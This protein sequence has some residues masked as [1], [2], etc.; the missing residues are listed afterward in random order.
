FSASILWQPSGSTTQST[1]YIPTAVGNDTVTVSVM[2]ACDTLT[3]TIY[4][5]VNN[6]PP[7]APLICGV[8]ADLLTNDYVVSWDNFVSP[9]TDYY[10]IYKETP[11]GSG[12]FS[13]LTTQSAS[14]TSFYIDNASDAS[15][16]PESYRIVRTDHCGGVSA[17]SAPHTGVSLS[18]APASPQGSLLT[19]TPYQ[20]AQLWNQNVFRGTTLSNMTLIA[21]LTPAATSYLDTTAGNWLY[22]I[23]IITNYT[24]CLVMRLA[25]AQQTAS[26]EPIRSNVIASI[27]TGIT[28]ASESAIGIS[29]NPAAGQFTVNF[30]ASGVSQLRVFDVIGQEVY[31]EQLNTAAG[32][33]NTQL[34]LGNLTPGIYMLQISSGSTV[35]TAKLVISR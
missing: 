2:N 13:L 17:P 8:T 14:I 35:S 11:L 22:Y 6:T 24:P 12:N 3:H 1:L 20:G 32:N 26:I 23:E 18:V 33:V 28:E 16:S 31:R 30:T 5:N 34:D 4:I 21:Q 7:A 15:V 19:W 10:D 27:I 9:S 25:S 29:P